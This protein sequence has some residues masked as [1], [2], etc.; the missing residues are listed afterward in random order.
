MNI[1]QRQVGIG[2]F[3]LLTAG[4]VAFAIAS[5]LQA[6]IGSAQL[7]LVSTLAFSMLLFAYWRGFNQ[8][9][10]IGIIV[11]ALLTVFGADQR[12]ITETVQISNVTAAIV[13]AL[14][15]GPAWV[16]GSMT[17]VHLLMIFRAQFVGIYVTPPAI[18]ISIVIGLGLVLI[19]LVT[20]SALRIAEA[21]AAQ[22]R[23]AQVQAEQQAA[24]LA[25]QASELRQQNEQQQKLISLV[26]TLETPTVSMAEGVLLA[27]LVGHL[28]SRRAQA[29]TTR[30][31]NMVSEQRTRLVILDISGV[32]TVDTQVAHALLKAIQAIRL[33]GCNVTITGIS[34]SV[35]TT[36][37]HLGITLEGVSIARSPQDALAAALV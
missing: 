6:D 31:L 34:A 21:N 35:A 13:A 9:R 7:G 33:L 37:T 22:A 23:Q 29:I 14:L 5:F 1:T 17:A 19:R 25:Q 4:S 36:I 27:P 15:A 32:P 20:D 26:T 24:E 18:I 12:T 11:I 10:Y 3:G 8:A 28:D 30:I 2:L 16:F